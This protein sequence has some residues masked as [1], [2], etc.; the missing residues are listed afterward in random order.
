MIHKNEQLLIFYPNNWRPSKT[1]GGLFAFL[2]KKRNFQ[3][4]VGRSST[5]EWLP[6]TQRVQKWPS[7]SNLNCQT[8]ILDIVHSKFEKRMF[9]KK[10]GFGF[11]IGLFCVFLGFFPYFSCTS[12]CGLA[13]Y[14]MKHW[15]LVFSLNFF[16]FCCILNFR[17]TVAV[18][19]KKII[20]F[21]SR[22][23]LGPCFELS[24]CVS[25]NVYLGFYSFYVTCCFDF[26]L[27]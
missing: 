12:T 10:V 25:F 6:D 9:L 21:F 7:D 8:L 18:M 2:Q 17:F 14:I 27:N 13:S 20:L 4:L 19:P 3:T 22:F 15:S 26:E 11:K 1:S 16:V 5:V 24:V 23:L